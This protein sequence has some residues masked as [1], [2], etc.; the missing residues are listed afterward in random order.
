[1]DK[2]HCVGCKDNYYNGNNDVGIKECWGL[3]TA[4]LKTRWRIRWNV[5]TFQENF[6]RC[7]VPS[8]FSQPGQTYF[9]DDISDF[10][11]ERKR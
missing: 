6:T 4:K 2:Q 3:K 11:S 9:T 5:P 1:M 7:R 8:C 10:P